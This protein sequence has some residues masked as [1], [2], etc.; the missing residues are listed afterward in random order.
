MESN[1]K[2]D[3][4]GLL[5]RLRD[6]LQMA[7]NSLRNPNQPFHVLL[8]GDTG[9]G[10]TYVKDQILKLAQIDTAKEV[11]TANCA[12]FEKELAASEIFGYEKGAH[13][14]AA[15]ASPG[16]VGIGKQ[17]L[18]LDEIGALL[19]NVQAKLLTFLDE[20]WYRSVG[21]TE[22]KH[23]STR[24]IAMTN[25]NLQDC[26][27]RKDFLN[28]FRTVQVPGLHAHRSDIPLLLD[29][30]APKTSWS[31]GDL[32][33]LLAYEW[34][35]N[36]RQLRDLA[37]QANSFA[38]DRK[39]MSKYFRMPPQDSALLWLQETRKKVGLTDT[40]APDVQG[41]AFRDVIELRERLMKSDRS[42]LDFSDLIAPMLSLGKNFNLEVSLR[43]IMTSQSPAESTYNQEF[44]EGM[45]WK[46]PDDPGIIHMDTMP[47]PWHHEWLDWCRLFCQDP[48]H[49]GDIVKCILAGKPTDEV[50]EGPEKFFD[51]G[52]GHELYGQFLSA[53]KAL[54]QIFYSPACEDADSHTGLEAESGL[55]KRPGD[56]TS[57]RAFKEVAENLDPDQY[58][59]HWVDHWMR[60]RPSETS[61]KF[62]FSINT[63]KKWF[64]DRRNGKSRAEERKKRRGRRSSK[65]KQGQN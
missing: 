10:K 16:L 15:A 59:D 42:V 60:C 5:R 36:I 32:L 31:I 43:D 2:V 9:A 54:T 39:Y 55:E 47:T 3:M 40:V 58:W 29:F 52:A 11:V 53:R 37:I 28:R 38:H 46:A 51:E 64:S 19:E 8:H 23:S 56:I 63:V 61:T 62:D 48:Q 65:S 20:G 6:D 35:G 25:A 24:I 14:T 30:F 27:L 18:V 44:L 34:P 22:N 13:S 26:P 4:P 50:R 49:P 57:W 45:A 41:P 33:R 12:G 7:A 21:G 17:I 1:P